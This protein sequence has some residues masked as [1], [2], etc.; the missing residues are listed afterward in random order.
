MIAIILSALL[1]APTA[2]AGPV[3]PDLQPTTKEG[4]VEALRD[5]HIHEK[6]QEIAELNS[7][8]I[9]A[10]GVRDRARYLCG[11]IIVMYRDYAVEMTNLRVY[12]DSLAAGTPDSAECHTK[13][14]GGEEALADLA[15]EVS[16]VGQ[17]WLDANDLYETLVQQRDQVCHELTTLGVARAPTE[18][19]F[20]SGYGTNPRLFEDLSGPLPNSFS[21]CPDYQLIKDLEASYPH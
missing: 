19:P 21:N 18:T 15:T 1:A 2:L 6:R 11:N 5:S 16:K 20:L 9:Q 14:K 4:A 13:L 8:I 7:Q 10:W 17:A 3:G 12:C